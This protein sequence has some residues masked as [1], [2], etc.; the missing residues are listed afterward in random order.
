ME[1]TFSTQVNT[2]FFRIFQEAMTNVARHAKATT[3]NIQLN[4]KD[5]TLMLAI[6]D[7]GVGMPENQKK[8]SLGILGMKERAA[9]LDG[10]FNICSIPKQGTNLTVKI[11]LK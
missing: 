10:E 3:V 2:T 7:N 5:N 4:R 1:D 8:H 11:P 6:Q 9:M